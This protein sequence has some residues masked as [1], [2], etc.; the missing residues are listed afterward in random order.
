MHSY[1]HEPKRIFKNKI[2]IKIKNEKIFNPNKYKHLKL[3]KKE[4]KLSL[5]ETPFT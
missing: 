4:S 5:I 2:R 3:K 1:F